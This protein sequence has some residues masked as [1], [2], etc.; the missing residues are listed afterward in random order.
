MSAGSSVPCFRH[1]LPRGPACHNNVIPQLDPTGGWLGKELSGPSAALFSKS[2]SAGMPTLLRLRYS[3]KR[4]SVFAV[5]PFIYLFSLTSSAALIHFRPPLRSCS[6]CDGMQCAGH[7]LKACVSLGGP[8]VRLSPGPSPQ[9]DLAG[10]ILLDGG[11]RR[12]LTGKLW[13]Q[14]SLLRPTRKEPFISLWFLMEQN[15]PSVPIAMLS[16][17]SPSQHSFCILS[18]ALPPA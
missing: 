7:M 12:I 11:M 3:R 16:T 13:L 4:A 18:G 9:V 15:F 1:G 10:S 6:T 8:C 5:L 14:H 17:R 2:L